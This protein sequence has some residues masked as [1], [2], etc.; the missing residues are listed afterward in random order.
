MTAVAPR[1][2]AHAI[3]TISSRHHPLVRRYRALAHSSDVK[4]DGSRRAVLLDGFHLLAEAA[5]AGISIESAVVE[6]ALLS[7]PDVEPI[8]RRLTLSGAQV[9]AVTKDLLDAMS[10]VRTPSGAVGI[11]VHGVMPIE[12]ALQGS[13][14]LAVMAHDVQDPGNVGAI[15]RA[16]EAAGATTFVSCGATADPF[17][18]KA[19]R[20]SMGSV[21]RLPI[22]RSTFE[23][24]VEVCRSQKVRLVAMTPRAGRSVFQ[25][26]LRGRCALLVGGEGPGLSSALTAVADECV[27]IPMRAPVESLNVAVAVALVLYE[28]FRQRESGFK[29]AGSARL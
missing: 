9:F 18:W 26:D 14:T 5:A 2:P 6:R 4:G 8:V 12:R 24:A 10:P 25:V 7:R 13:G 19:V 11:A 15:I 21:L 1:S 3:K 28:A 22:A 16:A 27:A 29:T 17:S 23:T 20:G